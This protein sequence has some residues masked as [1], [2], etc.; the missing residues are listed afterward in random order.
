MAPKVLVIGG[1][2]AF[3]R[4]LVRGLL[5]T[6]DLE[7]VVAGRDLARAQS[8]VDEECVGSRVGRATAVAL[9][10][11]IATAA[12]LRDTGA[13][14]VVD[15]AGPFQRQ[16]YHL[17]ERA[18]E[19]GLHYVDLADS[20][21]FVSGFHVLDERAQKASV[22]ALTGA[23]STPALSNAVLDHL[24][25]GWQAVDDVEIAISPGNRAPRGLA[26]VRSILSYAGKPVRV[27]E[28]GSWRHRPGWGAPV[29]KDIRGLGPRWLSLCE[30]PDLDVV[31]TRFAVRRSVT[32]NAG[33][34]LPVMHLGLFAATI[35]IRLGLLQSLEP[36]AET[37]RR[38]ADLLDGWGTDRGGMVVAVSGV[39]ADG[40]QVS[41]TW[42]LLA[43]AGDG[44]SIPTL[45][46]LAAV[47]AMASGELHRPG[48][49]VCAGVLPLDAIEREFAPYRIT[50]HV[51]LGTRR[52]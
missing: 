31:P 51:E 2:G 14:V 10:T 11:R 16:G 30:T 37:F 9:D 21:E 50:T 49:S 29:R 38:A 43:E 5:A 17:A 25:A 8:V 36:L 1:A 26:V 12:Q 52:E 18:I 42:T 24:T 19:A 33:L 34:E 45:P 39:G 20:R 23:S 4:R 48:A 22:T 6:T 40:T 47:R 44:P 32:F 7:V 41:A 3:G 13:F 15:A 35:A 28:N 46:A 27:W